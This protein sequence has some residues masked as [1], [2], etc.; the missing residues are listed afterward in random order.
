MTEVVFAFLA[1]VLFWMTIAGIAVRAFRLDRLEIE[2]TLEG[3]Y[4]KADRFDIA[5]NR[6]SLALCR[7]AFSR[8]YGTRSVRRFLTVFAISAAILLAGALTTFI[9]AYFDGDFRARVRE[10]ALSVG[11][12]YVAQMSTEQ[13]R[14]AMTAALHTV[15]GQ[16]S[17]WYTENDD[18]SR[19]LRKMGYEFEPA[20]RERIFRENLNTAATLEAY[21]GGGIEPPKPTAVAVAE[22][23]LVFL[24]AALVL[25][26]LDFCALIMT[27]R[28]FALD[29]GPLLAP[30]QRV[31]LLSGILGCFFVSVLGYELA[32]RLDAGVFLLLVVLVP[33]VVLAVAMVIG[34][35]VSDPKF[36][37]AA[38][39]VFACFSGGLIYFFGFPLYHPW[40]NPGRSI[41]FSL[42]IGAAMQ[43]LTREALLMGMASIYPLIAVIS[44]W[45]AVAIVRVFLVATKTVVLGQIYG[46]SVLSGSTWLLGFLTATVSSTVALYSLIRFFT[47]TSSGT[48]GT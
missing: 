16:A 34:F 28:V 5:V 39:V 1:S 32:F 15:C 6:V 41:D 37:L 22:M 29:A 17:C 43:N 10:V 48:G 30:L 12:Q 11:P 45:T 27:L 40:D 20:Y 23:V 3:I 42:P 46:A 24:G 26:A 36:F 13:G 2:K 47:G 4:N 7:F 8:I 35:A 38:L 9:P 33:C 25:A 14:A 19:N 18:A 21:F 44:L 31:A